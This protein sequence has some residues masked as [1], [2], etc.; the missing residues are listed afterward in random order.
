MAAA[1]PCSP[2]PEGMRWLR[3]GLRTVADWPS[4]VYEAGDPDTRRYAMADER[5]LRDGATKLE[6]LHDAAATKPPTVVRLPAAR[7]RPA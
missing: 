3:F 6:A 7:P 5:M 1:K 4:S 2:V